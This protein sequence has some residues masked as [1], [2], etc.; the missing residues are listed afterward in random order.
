MPHINWK[1]TLVNSC[2]TY[3]FLMHL[4]K[5]SLYPLNVRENTAKFVAESLKA[6]LTFSEI[7]S[8]TGDL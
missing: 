8:I 3:I 5:S 6:I 1:D 7:W 2:L 4:Q